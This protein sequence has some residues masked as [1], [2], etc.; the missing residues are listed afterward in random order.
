M[1]KTD[2][3]IRLVVFLLGTVGIVFFVMLMARR[4]RLEARTQEGFQTATDCAN[5]RAACPPVRIANQLVYMCSNVS[6]AQDDAMN[7]M[8]CDDTLAQSLR[9]D[10]S[11]VSKLGIRDAICYAVGAGVASKVG[12]NY[13][14]CYQ[15]PPYIT[16]DSALGANQYVNPSDGI[17]DDPN[18]T[19]MVANLET[20][21]GTY[22]GAGLM[23][24]TAMDKTYKNIDYVSTAMSTIKTAYDQVA[25]IRTA[26]CTGTL[27]A[28]QTSTCNALSTFG[29]LQTDTTYS[30]L[31]NAYTT[32]VDSYNSMKSYFVT[33]IEK[34]FSGL[35][36][37]PLPPSTVAAIYRV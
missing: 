33:D 20:A 18:P 19:T 3:H 17:S 16:F 30:A 5:Y 25:A 28:D 12:S 4:L 23:V 24:G 10:P 21:C 9:L 14:V 8:S 7:L 34:K 15:R 11:H 6:R 37:K 32:L 35:N 29:T 31:T 13:Y 1:R 22:G 27:N 36:C 26:R 2:K